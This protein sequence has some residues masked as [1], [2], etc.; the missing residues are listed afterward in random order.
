MAYTVCADCGCFEK[1]IPYPCKTLFPALSKLFIVGVTESAANFQV[2][3]SR[4]VDEKA[5]KFISLKMPWEWIIVEQ[6]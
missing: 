6:T 3:I 5:L 1:D 2:D 4:V